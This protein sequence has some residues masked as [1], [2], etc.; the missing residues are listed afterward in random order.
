MLFI[1]VHD[2]SKLN[3]RIIVPHNT[4]KR[5]QL[6]ITTIQNHNKLKKRGTSLRGPLRTLNNT[7]TFRFKRRGTRTQTISVQETLGRR[8]TPYATYD[9]PHLRPQKMNKLIINQDVVLCFY[10]QHE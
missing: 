9:R 1:L 4:A 5:K 10:K 8:L 3:Y 2:S 6:D 7:P